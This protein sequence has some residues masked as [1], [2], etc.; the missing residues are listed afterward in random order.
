VGIIGN[1]FTHPDFR[2]RGLAT[3]VTGAVAAHLLQHCGL[4][5]L[6]VDPANYSARHVYEQLG[7]H[8]AGSLIEAMSTRRAVYSPFPMLRR[9]LS[10]Q[11]ADGPGTEVIDI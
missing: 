4:I 9:A 11:R 8:E 7:F 2:S 3:Q 1:V 6:N 10:R 5:V